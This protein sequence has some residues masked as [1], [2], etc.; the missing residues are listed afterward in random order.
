MRI[1]EFLRGSFI[2]ME[3]FRI[4]ICRMVKSGPGGATKSIMAL[5]EH[6]AQRYS[7]TLL[8]KASTDWGPLQRFFEIDLSQVNLVYLHPLPVNFARLLRTQ[9]QWGSKL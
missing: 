2:G 5:A 8:T 6:F 4:G 3:N 9:G 1:C 7:V